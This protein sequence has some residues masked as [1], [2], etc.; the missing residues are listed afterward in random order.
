VNFV[1]IL[2]TEPNSQPLIV[3]QARRRGVRL[4]DGRLVY[5]TGKASTT[6]QAPRGYRWRRAHRLSL[7]SR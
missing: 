3:M 7:G 6:P 1:T 5:V 2:R 4:A